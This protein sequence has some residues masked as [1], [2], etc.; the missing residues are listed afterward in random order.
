MLRRELGLTK[1]YNLVNDPDV[2]DTV[3]RDVAR[4]R[5]IHVELDRA[6]LAAYDWADID[7]GH[8]FHEYRRMTRFTLSREARVEVFDRL[9]KEN[10]RRAALQGE[11]PGVEAEEDDE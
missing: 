3:D 6:V 10:H 1:L 8:G 5:E 4:L 2:S 9:L 11:A 7:P